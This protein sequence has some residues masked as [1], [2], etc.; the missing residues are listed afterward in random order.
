MK[1]LDKN[2]RII[3]DG[4][5]IKVTGVFKEDGIYE[6]KYWHMFKALMIDNGGTYVSAIRNNCEVIN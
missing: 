1:E 6:V 3:K 5:F 2:N 4:S